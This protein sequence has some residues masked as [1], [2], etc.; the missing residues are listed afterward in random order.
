M[1]LL[2]GEAEPGG[3]APRSGPGGVA[4]AR[5]LTAVRNS[6]PLNSEDMGSPPSFSYLCFLSDSPVI[7]LRSS[8]V[9][10]GFF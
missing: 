1:P 10:L 6:F 5:L 8:L 3:V 2:R 9:T 4:V 7:F